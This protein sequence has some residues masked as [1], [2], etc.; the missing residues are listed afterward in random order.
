MLAEEL[1]VKPVNET[2]NENQNAWY[3]IKEAFNKEEEKLFGR[4]VTKM[5][6]VETSE[7]RPIRNVDK[8]RLSGA[9]TKVDVMFKRITLNNVTALTKVVSCGGIITSKLL[10]VKN[11]QS[12][13]N[14]FPMWK[15]RL[16]NQVKDL[17]K[18][19]VRV[20]VLSKGNKLKKKHSTTKKIFP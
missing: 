4:L 2:P 15:T 12:K 16:E 18:D 3:T 10:G 7:I 1:S 20:I 17:C 13:Q 5:D 9:S 14:N 19:L 11:S 8:K 6:S